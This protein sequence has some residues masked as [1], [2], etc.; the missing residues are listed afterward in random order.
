VAIPVYLNEYWNSDRQ[1]AAHPFPESVLNQQVCSLFLE[2][3]ILPVTPEIFGAGTSPKFSEELT[4][5]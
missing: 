4:L 5:T 3:V 2:R 1:K